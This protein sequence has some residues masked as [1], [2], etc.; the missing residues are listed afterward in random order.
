MA[1]LHMQLQ[2]SVRLKGFGFSRPPHARVHDRRLSDW[3]SAVAFRSPNILPRNEH[4]LIS[5]RWVLLAGQSLSSSGYNAC[6]GR[7][8]SLLFG[9]RILQARVRP[10]LPGKVFKTQHSFHIWRGA[11]SSP[12]RTIS[13]SLML[14]PF[15]GFITCAE[16]SC[17]RYSCLHRRQNESTRALRCLHLRI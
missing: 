5:V 3:R 7:R 2:V 12:R 14:L 16:R 6:T 10:S 17:K 9:S 8:S 15:P 11:L 13:P 4:A 1:P